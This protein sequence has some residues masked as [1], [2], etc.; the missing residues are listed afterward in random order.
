MK[1]RPVA[2]AQLFRADGRTDGHEADSRF[3]QF[4]ESACTG[5]GVPAHVM[6]AYGGVEAYEYLRPFL[7]SAL[8][9]GEC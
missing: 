6:K 5:K 8:V 1:I 3:S 7:N 4:C 2:A 9:G